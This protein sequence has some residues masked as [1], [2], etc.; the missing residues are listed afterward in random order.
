VFCGI[1]ARLIALEVDV[2][3]VAAREEDNP[4]KRVPVQHLH[5][6]EIRQIPVQTG[7]RALARLLDGVAG[8]LEGRAARS[9]DAVPDPFG[10]DDMVRVARGE[11]G[12]GL[13]DPD[14]GFPPGDDFPS[15]RISFT[16]CLCGSQVRPPL[17]YRST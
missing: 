10:K 15:Y 17:R 5:Q 4:V 1:S 6:T 8:E 12:P 11:I 2:R 14:N 16:D 7:C 3:L 9:E 13:R